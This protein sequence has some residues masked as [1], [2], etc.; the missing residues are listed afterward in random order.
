MMR[1]LLLVLFFSSL[2]LA[3]VHAA[4]AI[5]PRVFMALQKAQQAQQ[6]GDYQAAR[7]ALAAVQAKPDSLEQV[8]LWRSQGYLA[9]AEGDAGKAASLLEKVVASG[10]LE[11]EQLREDHANLARLSLA[12]GRH[13]RV[14]ELLSPVPSDAS[15]EV[16]QM[17]VQAYQGLGQPAKALPL[18]ERYVQAN[19]KVDDDWLQFLVSLNADLKRYSAAERWQRQ[20]LGRHPDDARRWR[21]LAGLQ[22]LGGE[23]HKALATLRTAHRK[24][25]RFSAEELDQLVLLASAAGQPWQGA[26]L[27]EGLLAD[28]TLARNAVR[29][30]RL[31]LLWWQARERSKAAGVYRDL[32]QRSGN[33]K[34]WL[35]VA[36][37]ELEQSRWRAGLDA[38][39]AAEKAGAERAKVRQWRE[40]AQ[41][42]LEFDGAPHLAR[43]N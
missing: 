7:Q 30:E 22:Q 35:Q 6:K 11:G 41:S 10:K 14:V 38:L 9:W 33:A 31:G 42:Q 34:H 1:R 18:A 32:A 36:Q 27:L 4:Q 5:D 15:S 40:W 20:L 39:A 16:L 37:L 43:A 17:L 13:G 3:A 2:P 25:L 21:Q 26:K 28:G 19:P 24:G 12:A 23:Q 29:E 8:M